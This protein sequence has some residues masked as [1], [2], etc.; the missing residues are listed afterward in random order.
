MGI[1]F[2]VEVGEVVAVQECSCRIQ[3]KSI[4]SLVVEGEVVLLG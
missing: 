4:Q 3:K 2:T 1:L